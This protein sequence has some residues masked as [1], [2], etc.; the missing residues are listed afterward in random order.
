MTAPVVSV[1]TP[2]YNGVFKSDG[3]SREFMFIAPSDHDPTKS[4]PLG[5]A[6][7]HLNGDAEGYFWPGRRTR[8]ELRAQVG[9]FALRLGRPGATAADLDARVRAGAEAGLPLG[10][11]RAAAGALTDRLVR[12]PGRP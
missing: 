11:L 8:A 4:Y 6:W 2:V 7:H 1:I 3:R 12:A 10:F 5:I 9:A